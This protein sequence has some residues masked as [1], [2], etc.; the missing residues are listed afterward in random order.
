MNL[1]HRIIKGLRPEVTVKWPGLLIWGEPVSEDY[2]LEVIRRTD[3][4]N[5]SYVSTNDKDFKRDFEW[6]LYGAEKDFA[7]FH[8]DADVRDA[9]W[10]AM[11]SAHFTFGGLEL[12]HLQQEWIA[13]SYI[14]G[15][16]GWMHPD[17]KINNFKNFGKWPSAEEI[18]Y[19]LDMIVRA[20]PDLCMNLAWWDKEYSEVIEGDWI[21]EPSGGWIVDKGKWHFYP[22][23]LAE[24]PDSAK[25]NNIV[26]LLSINP[27]QIG[28]GITW[29]IAELKELWGEHY[30]SSRDAFQQT[31]ERV[32]KE[33]SSGGTSE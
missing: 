19:D 12:Q 11:D 13:T 7:N 18:Q 27:L 31:Y 16:N 9:Y 4:A 25:I 28:S 30:K 26:D 22:F 5:T 17:G 1:K 10:D 24:I 3:M 2:A 6:L 14:G 15:N 21:D 23:T 29:T 20:F 32:R 8:T 33:Q